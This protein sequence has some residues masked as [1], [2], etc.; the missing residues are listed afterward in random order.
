MTPKLEQ[1]LIAKYPL[2]LAKTQLTANEGDMYFG[3]CCG[4][5]WYNLLDTLFW[6][7]Q[8]YITETNKVSIATTKYNLMREQVLV[9]DY[10]LFNAQYSGYDNYLL[11]TFREQLLNNK[12]KPVVDKVEQIVATQVKEK[13][14]TLRFYYDGFGN[15]R[16]MGMC[17][18]AEALSSSICEVCGNPGYTR[19][20]R[21]IGTVCDTHAKL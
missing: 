19:P 2:I 15:E 3:I 14:G 20:N 8:N 1:K 9:G 6:N 10:T 16:I 18:M 17:Y 11:D 5:G 4:D 13:F 12:P 21:S 7:I